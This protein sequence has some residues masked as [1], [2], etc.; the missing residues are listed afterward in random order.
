M[1]ER[2][3]YC[4][5]GIAACCGSATVFAERYTSSDGYLEVI[6]YKL[7][8]LN[9]DGKAEITLTG[10]VEALADCKG[11]ELS[12]DVFDRDNRKLGVLQA[13][14]G[15]LGRHD[16]WVLGPGIFTAQD[17]TK[18]AAASADHVVAR[19]AQCRRY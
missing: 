1:L 3:F 14:H 2:F 6:G 18:N 17:G 10:R 16:V 19:D 8:I 11:V 13:M 5:I 9:R 15:A 4:A 7:Q 12:F